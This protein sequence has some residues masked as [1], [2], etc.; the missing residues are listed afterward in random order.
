MLPQRPQYDHVHGIVAEASTL[1]GDLAMIVNGEAIHWQDGEI[2][3]SA[4]WLWEAVVEARR[5][6]A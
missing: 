5:R 4:A 6:H 3:R 2:G 1:V